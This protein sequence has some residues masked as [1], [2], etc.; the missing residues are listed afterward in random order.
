MYGH[1]PPV[2][3][4]LA[5]L[6]SSYHRYS[7]TK[8]WNIP[9]VIGPAL[10]YLCTLLLPSFPPFLPSFPPPLLLLSFSSPLILSPP[11]FLFSSLLSFLL[12]SSSLLLTFSSPPSSPP[13]PVPSTQA[14]GYLKFLNA[15]HPFG[16]L[17]EQCCTTTILYPG[18]M[19]HSMQLY[20]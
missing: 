3:S 8:F 4:T 12:L 16:K 14:K 9:F 18:Y 20:M 7:R 6:L 1:S 2:Y 13:P 11:H 19:L 5:L 10:D 15:L 17:F